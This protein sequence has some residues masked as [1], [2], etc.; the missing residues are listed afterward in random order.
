MPVRLLCP[1]CD[2]SG[3]TDST[4]AANVE[5]APDGLSILADGRLFFTTRFPLLLSDANGLKDVYEWSG[6]ARTLITSG[7]SRFDA[8][9]LSVSADGADAFFFTHDNLVPEEDSN[10]GLMRIYDARVNGGFFRLP[11]SVPCQASDECHGPG[12]ESAPAPPIRS[13]GKTTAGNVFVCPKNRVKKRGHCVKKPAQ[14]KK[15]KHAKKGDA[16]KRNAKSTEKRGGRN[17]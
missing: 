3:T 11:T 16:K 6:G 9:L 4:L 10:G 13:S 7:I 2:T 17:A 15:K 14:R 5:L 8:A 1:S 12:S